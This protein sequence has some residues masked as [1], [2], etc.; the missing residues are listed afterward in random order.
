MT[1]A[2]CSKVPGPELPPHPTYYT[3]GSGDLAGISW[4]A[5]REVRGS[6]SEEVWAIW[7]E[8]LALAI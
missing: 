4:S 6:G 2:P 1:R 5:G 7:K 8:S 3:W